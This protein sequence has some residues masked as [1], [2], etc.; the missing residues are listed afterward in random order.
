MYPSSAIR[1]KFEINK[2][3]FGIV[4]KISKTRS[5]LSKSQRLNRTKK[6]SMRN[7]L[8]LDFI[9][10][11]R[12]AAD[13]VVILDGIVLPRTV[14]EMFGL[15]PK[16]VFPHGD[17]G[18][19]TNLVGLITSVRT[20]A[21]SVPSYSATKRLLH[22]LSQVIE[23]CGSLAE[24]RNRLRE[25]TGSNCTPE[26]YLC[27]GFKEARHFLAQNPEVM[28]TES[29]KG[30]I[31][32]VCLRQTLQDKRNAFHRYADQQW[33][34]RGTATPCGDDLGGIPQQT[35]R[36]TGENEDR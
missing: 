33:R 5:G 25:R 1:A 29:D 13:N 34:V 9:S 18:S 14:R 23:N 15:G 35:Q 36:D 30:H 26:Q 28:V 2:K 21:D 7:G 22:G 8:P 3:P 4:K 31:T 16:F 20:I 12:W 32:I 24:A 10:S 11:M 19:R 27:R 6:K 17:S